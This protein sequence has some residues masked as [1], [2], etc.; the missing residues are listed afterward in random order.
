MIV[1]PSQKTLSSI[2]RMNNF[3][4]IGLFFV[5]LMEFQTFFLLW[6]GGLILATW[7]GPILLSLYLLKLTLWGRRSKYSWT[8]KTELVLKIHGKTKYANVS[9]ARHIK[10]E[11]VGLGI[12]FQGYQNRGILAFW[13]LSAIVAWDGRKIYRYCVLF[14]KWHPQIFIPS[15]TTIRN[16]LFT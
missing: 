7:D 11:N 2:T 3:H 10:S 8:L 14:L 15:S 4:L 12:I 1:K 13:R 9:H 6:V 16:H 5:S